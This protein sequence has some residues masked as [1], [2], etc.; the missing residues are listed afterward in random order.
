MSSFTY[1][2]TG[3]SRSLGLGYSRALLA[4]SPA[5]KIVAAARNPSKA[6]GLQALEQEFKGRVYLLRLDVAD[7]EA[8]KAAAQELE[9][10][11]FLA[12]GGLDALV[13]NAGVAESPSKPSELP[14]DE[15]LYHFE[16][17]LFGVMN[18]TAAFLPLL[19]KGTGKQVFG[20]SSVCGSLGGYFSENS[21]VTAYCISK[22]ALNMYL[23]KLASELD[24]DG[25]TVVS[26]H[27][28]YVKT[29]MNK[30]QGEITTE[31]AVDLAVK[32]VFLRKNK[33]GEFR[34]Y[35]GNEMP[36]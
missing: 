20:V 32:N 19:K 7:A 21:L 23:K 30:G 12:S 26:F 10:S 13:N 14:K 33:N 24:G 25:F 5:V 4:S 3:A 6:E 1:L 31:E 29:D 17:N 28:G 27:P 36:W 16:T 8:A 9:K 15:V 2:V 34:S 11:G 22:A 18:V 35:D